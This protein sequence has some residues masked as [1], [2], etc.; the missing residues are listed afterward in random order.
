MTPHK[1]APELSLLR[2]RNAA[3]IAGVATPPWTPTDGWRERATPQSPPAP[4]P[5][6][7]LLFLSCLFAVTSASAPGYHQQWLQQQQWHQEWLQQQQPRP[8][9]ALEPRSPLQPCFSVFKLSADTLSTEFRHVA[10]SWGHGTSGWWDYPDEAAECVFVLEAPANHRLTLQLH[11]VSV[12]Q[13]Q[14]GATAN[15]SDAPAVRVY[16]YT[17]LGE[18]SLA[19]EICRTTDRGVLLALTTNVAVVTTTLS[20]GR[21][22]LLARVTPPAAP[23]PAPLEAAPEQQD[24]GGSLSYDEADDLN[25][26]DGDAAASDAGSTLR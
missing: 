22:D 12:P 4:R 23:A 15:C 10:A 19:D 14:P 24:A 13:D 3:A 21:F 9:P 7:M 18:L 2:W 25:A 20:S 26:L 17:S 16:N 6:D 8:A 1:G 11:D 5:T